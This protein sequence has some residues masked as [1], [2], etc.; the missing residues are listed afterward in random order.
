MNRPRSYDPYGG[1]SI[2]GIILS[3]ALPAACYHPDRLERLR[4]WR[5]GQ[6]TPKQTEKKEEK[7][8]MVG[9]LEGEAG[10]A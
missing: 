2:V 5:D 4:A 8:E 10:P 3:D 6:V 9:T 7:N 1:F